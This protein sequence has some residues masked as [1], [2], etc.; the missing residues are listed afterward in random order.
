M[1]ISSIIIVILSILLVFS[2]VGNV[3]VLSVLDCLSIDNIR[4][5][6][7]MNYLMQN[8]S[9]E[10]PEIND[11]P[12]TIPEETPPEA[13]TK[14]EEVEVEETEPEIAPLVLWDRS[15]IK[16]TCFGLELDGFYGPELS[17]LIENN[18]NKNIMI[19]FN[20]VAINGYMLDPFWSTTI[21]SGNKVLD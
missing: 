1:K 13:E 21:T 4:A 16:I 19:S 18:T 5:H 3:M 6:I 15:G 12:E 7:A 8:S 17:V 2:I 20:D 10:D 14:E 11:E 9:C